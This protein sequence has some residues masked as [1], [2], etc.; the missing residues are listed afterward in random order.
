MTTSMLQQLQTAIDD[1]RAPEA[2]RWQVR[3]QLSAVRDALLDS[4]GLDA[5]DGWLTAR[6]GSVRRERDALL[7]RVARLGPAV[8]DSPDVPRL[9]RDLRRLR[10]DLGHHLQ[11][12]RDL[13]WDE[14]ELELGGSD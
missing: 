6:G 1:A 4:T 10:V 14:V 3:R 9:R 11:R 12:R 5:G 7:D 13:A 2:W 8:L